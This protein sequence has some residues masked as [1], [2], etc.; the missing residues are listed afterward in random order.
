MVSGSIAFT[1]SMILTI[2]IMVGCYFIIIKIFPD[3]EQRKIY[4]KYLMTGLSDEKRDFVVKSF[5]EIPF[6]SKGQVALIIGAEAVPD[7][8]IKLPANKNYNIIA[9][10]EQRI[11]HDVFIP[12]S[13]N[14]YKI[15][16]NWK[17]DL[18]DLDI[19]MASF[20]FA[21]HYSKGFNFSEKLWHYINSKIKPGGY[22]IGNFFDPD[23]KIFDEEF[24]DKYM[25]FLTKEQVL[26]LFK[27]YDI[28][29]FEEV[30]KPIEIDKKEYIE[31]YYEV[32]AKKK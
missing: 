7:S 2:A 17:E 30:N 1:L 11:L 3:D 9:F 25:S 4:K 26:F 28:L 15:I 16:D 29:N 19:V 5:K 8:D 14:N 12:D 20:V 10:D 32:F 24:R 21:L 31:H 18:P 22:F 23:C 6:A 27:D 13:S